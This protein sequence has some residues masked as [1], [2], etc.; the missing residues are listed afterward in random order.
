MSENYFVQIILLSLVSVVRITREAMMLGL[1]Q[2]T[3][4]PNDSGFCS[5][6]SSGELANRS[7]QQIGNGELRRLQFRVFG[8]MKDDHKG[9]TD[10]T[11]PENRER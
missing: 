3:H 8:R 4:M 1:F 6:S 2:P 10:E 7:H 9:G 11:P 5:M